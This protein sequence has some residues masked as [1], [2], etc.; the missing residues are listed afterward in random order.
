MTMGE[1][2]AVLFV[3]SIVEAMRPLSADQVKTLFF[4]LSDF[5]M[6]GVLPDPFTDPTSNAIFQ[7]A[8][9]N[10]EKNAEKYLAKKSRRQRRSRG[11][12]IKGEKG[13]GKR[14]EEKVK[15]AK[16]SPIKENTKES[17]PSVTTFEPPVISDMVDF[18]TARNWLDFEITMFLDYYQ[19]Y[20][21]WGALPNNGDWQLAAE[22]WYREQP[23]F[24]A[25]FHRLQAEEDKLKKR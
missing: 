10:I 3:R 15:E 12:N 21:G 6:D 16:A 25:E 23:K 13:K 8:K 19:T 14:E 24:V 5:A 1:N 18:C 11:G 9:P 4:A 20:K 17:K 7:L 2:N 22:Q